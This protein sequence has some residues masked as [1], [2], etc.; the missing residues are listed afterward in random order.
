[1]VFSECF[2]SA[3]CIDLMYWQIQES[4]I[5]VISLHVG[6]PG[7]FSGTS[8]VVTD[9]IASYQR[10]NYFPRHVTF[11]CFKI[12][13][14]VVCLCLKVT[15]CFTCRSN[16]M[17]INALRFRGVIYLYNLLLKDYKFFRLERVSLQYSLELINLKRGTV[18]FAIYY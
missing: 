14:K 9:C 18:G 12:P 3:T 15:S 4:E 6:C 5:L 17:Q 2:L 1:M 16:E 11:L 13:K 8:Q 10:F 7:C